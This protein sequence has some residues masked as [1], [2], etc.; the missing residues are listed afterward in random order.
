M[1][2]ITSQPKLEI[3]FVFVKSRHASLGSN[4]I[5]ANNDVLAF[6]KALPFN[7]RDNVEEHAES[8]IK[9]SNPYPQLDT[10]LKR[11]VKVLDVAP[12]TVVILG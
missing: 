1:D 8:I 9:K 5:V 4:T 11:K 12:E 2:F 6:Y 10:I 7:Y 3:S